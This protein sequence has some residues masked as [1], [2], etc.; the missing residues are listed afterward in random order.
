MSDHEPIDVPNLPDHLRERCTVVSDGHARSPE[1]DSLVVAWLHHACRIDENPVLEVA[2]AAARNLDL[3]LIV[4][5]GF[6]GSQH[7]FAND[8]QTLFMLEGWAELQSKLRAHDITMS[9][10]PPEAG[11][12]SGLRHLAR[13][14]RVLV[15]EDHPRNPYPAWTRGIATQVDGT[16]IAVDASCLLPGTMV[17][18]IHDRAFK[19][20]DACSSGWNARIDRDWPEADLTASPAEERDLPPG[21]LDLV[22]H[23]HRDLRDLV[24]SW[25]IDHA[26]GP[27]AGIRGGEDEGLARWNRFLESGI[28]RYHRRRNQAEEDGTSGLSPWIHHGAVSPF[29]LAREASRR[30]GEGADKFLDEL[31][32][33]RELSFHFCRTHHNHDRPGAVPAWARKT[34]EAHRRD[35]RIRR[36]WE[37]LSRG[38]TGDGLWDLAQASLRERG[39]LHNNL[40]MT[41]GKA[42]LEWCADVPETLDRL[43]DLNDRYALDGRDP[44]SIG[45]LLWCLGLF[46]RPFPEDRPVTGTL[47][48]RPTSV[49]ARRLDLDRYQARIRGSISRDRILVIG[50]GIAGSMAARTLL[51]HGHEVV[52][53]DKGRG[54]GG[55]TSTRRRG[56]DPTARH[57]HGCQVLRLRGDHRRTL[58]RSWIDDGIVTPWRPRLRQAD[59][60]VGPPS[61]DWYVGNPRMNA[62]V[63]HLQS[64][65]RVRFGQLV[66]TL[67]RDSEGWHALDD[68]GHVIESAPRVVLAL[69]AP[70]AQRLL[71]TSIDDLSSPIDPGLIERLADVK[72]DPTWTFMTHG[73][74]VDPGFDVAADP[75]PEV[76]WICRDASRPG[77]EDAGA[78]TMHASPD[79]TRRHVDLDKEEVEPHLRLMAEGILGTSLPRGDAHRWR[80]S[81]VTHPAGIDHLAT[82][83]GTLMLCGD[84]CLGNRVEHAIESGIAAAGRILRNPDAARVDAAA[85]TLFERT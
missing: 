58:T 47:R 77:R 9:I 21:A 34:L 51:D 83:D 74:D 59:G 70:Q 50:A 76:S 64:D 15:T 46:D 56:S 79:W 72:F 20:R 39:W 3:P 26:V 45:G 38:R 60:T 42:I 63:S 25:P 53:L 44:N 40:R 31:L 12:S 7:D 73:V 61:D 78:W 14:A 10:T 69:P 66:A 37:T 18:G 23:D 30:G 28:D 75:T 22:D 2:C 49:H 24:G 32:V 80:H 52:V 1:A 36:S 4:H 84:W 54:P 81:L 8:R 71:E 5:A 65:L 11:G 41:W 16:T 68:E 48:S 62:L 19:F 6:G 35:P 57:D 17:P 82:E 27:V 43:L 33:W 67:R 29:R 85:G 13:R 55:R